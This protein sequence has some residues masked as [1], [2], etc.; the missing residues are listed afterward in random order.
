MSTGVLYVSYD[1]A[2]DPLGQSQVL[3]YVE[4][5]AD[6]GWRFHLMTF[7]KPD[8]WADED[9][10]RRLEARLAERSIRWHPL[11]YRK[12]PPVVGTALDLRDGVRQ[13]RRIAAD[14][15]LSLV[16][17][18]SY[19]SA[20]V[21]LRVHRALGVPFLF[22]MRGLYA[23]ERVDGGLWRA[24]G[25]LYSLTKRLEHDFMASAAGVVTLTRA[26]RP[27]VE[28]LLRGAGGRGALAVLP[29]CVALDR[30]RMRPAPDGPPRLTYLGSI[31]TWYLLEPMMDFARTFLETV[32]GSTVEYVVNGGWDRV[33]AVAAARGVPAD[34][35]HVGSA[36][37]ADVP[38]ALARSSATFFLIRPG[39]S[40]VAS[41]ATK[42]GESLAVGR[43]VAANAGVG[44][45]AD[46]IQ[47]DG[48]G[49]VVD[50]R[51][52]TGWPAAVEALAA[53]ARDPGTAARCRRSAEARY[54]L[55]DGVEA[56]HALYRHMLGRG[57]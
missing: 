19:P 17:A 32:P 3:P 14:H 48:V 20:L 41:A 26:S 1:G 44:D 13:A 12:D 46:V 5:L 53:M 55:A 4:G 22:D 36:D 50:P 21:A 38:D 40:K 10:R 51:D 8:R 11:P 29:T 45:T 37:H 34:R 6:R 15:D 43:P 47:E 54:A 25:P 30:F 23:E 7:E 9:A 52:P 27:R 18:R 35:L 24:G 33:R 49:V 31:G 56:Y 28:E 2:L 57:P 16:H 42:F 39:G